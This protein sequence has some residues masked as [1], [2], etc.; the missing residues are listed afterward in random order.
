ASTVALLR[1]G[2]RTTT[3]ILDVRHLSRSFGGLQ[4]VADVSFSASRGSITGLIGP[5]GAGKS[6]TLAI[7]AGSLRS[8]AGS[9]FFGGTD[10]TGMPS[11][12]LARLGLARTFQMAGDFDRLT[13]LENLLVAAPRQRG[14]SIRAIYSPRRAW[15]KQ[16]AELVEKGRALLDR[17]ELADHEDAYA[18]EL[19]GGQRRLME[20]AR[21]L[22][23]DPSLLLLDEPMAGVNPRLMHHLGEHLLDLA[24]S[25]LAIVLVEHELR[26]IEQVC[27][28]VVV[29]AQGKVIG[30]GSMA[31]VRQMEEVLEAYI[32]G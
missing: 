9:V 21:A 5:N 24:R 13:V 23:A 11:H 4:A 10:V 28:H 15:R 8:S 27:D 19:S 17:F 22:M 30:A 3:P 18:G 31:E 16:E 29:L 26:L 1:P 25:G 2:D 32:A 12:R 20:L 7:V 6:T 14:E